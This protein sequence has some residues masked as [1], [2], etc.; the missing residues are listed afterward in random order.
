MFDETGNPPGDQPVKKDAQPKP[1]D[2]GVKE[3]N[4][5]SSVGKTER[6]LP[7]EELAER[8]RIAK[9]QGGVGCGFDRVPTKEAVKDWYNSLSKEEKAALQDPRTEV[10]LTATASLVGTREHNDKLTQ[11]RGDAVKDILEK[12]LGVKAKILTDPQGFTNAEENEA[13]KEKDNHR[14]RVVLI[15]ILKGG[16]GEGQAQPSGE[17][18]PAIETRP[19]IGQAQPSREEPSDKEVQPPKVHD[20]RPP[21]DFRK[22]PDDFH[23]RKQIIL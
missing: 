1:A 8:A 3:W 17:K 18:P 14:D 12:D 13:P 9:P 7:P 21:S 22:D 20:T 4:V 2:G 19:P 10:V 16:K 23:K 5:V 6:A 11:R 15:D